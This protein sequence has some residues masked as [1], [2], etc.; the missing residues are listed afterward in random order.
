MAG[1]SKWANI[2][3]RKARMDAQKN[4][5]YSK[6]SKAII[7][8][9]RRGGGDP[10][11]NAALRA[12]LNKAREYNIPQD[13]VTRAIQR[14]TGELAGVSYEELV[15]E[16]YGP[17]GVA[18][19]LEIMTDNRNRTAGEIRYLFSKHGGNLGETGCVAWMFDRRGLLVI[20][21]CALDEEELLE[22]ALEAG[23]EDLAGGQG[24]WE[25]YTAVE[26]VYSVKE[27]L[28]KRG[29]LVASAGVAMVPRTTVQPEPQ[30]VAPLL[31][32]LDALDDHDDVQNVY[33][34][35]DIPDEVMASLE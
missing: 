22:A 13:N 18:V 5:L 2:K 32:L 12:A 30:A 31:R 27:A 3:H 7:A 19:L 1:H 9:A 26:A 20:D 25:I 17:G 23:A 34:N 11:T 16:G 4:K 24:S 15:Y 21:E 8:A 10:E 6:I 29:V 33:A 35:F 28:E 14:G